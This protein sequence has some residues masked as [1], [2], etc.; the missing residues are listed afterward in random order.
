MTAVTPTVDEVARMMLAAQLDLEPEQICD[1][2]NP[3]PWMRH[4][5]QTIVERFEL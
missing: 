1:D 4:A 5:A 3:A 2:V